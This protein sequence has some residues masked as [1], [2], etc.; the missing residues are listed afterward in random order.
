MQVLSLCYHVDEIFLDRA[1][2]VYPLYLDVKFLARGGSSSR[3][4][5]KQM[6]ETWLW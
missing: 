3:D 5:Q 1:A 4:S 6:L 2:L